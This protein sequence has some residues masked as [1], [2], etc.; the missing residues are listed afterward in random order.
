[1]IAHLLSLAVRGPGAHWPTTV[2]GAASGC[3]SK[4]TLHPWGWKPWRRGPGRLGSPSLATVTTVDDGRRST[5]SIADDPAP[6]RCCSPSW[7]SSSSDGAPPRPPG[8]RPP[9]PVSARV[10]AVAGV[11]DPTGR[12]CPGRAAEGSSR[13]LPRRRGAAGRSTLAAEGPR[14]PGRPARRAGRAAGRVGPGPRPHPCAR[15]GRAAPVGRRA[16]RHPGPR[17]SR[18][19]TSYRSG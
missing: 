8:Q 9:A 18:R 13:H 19:A 16:A 11:A 3:A 5:R 4:G 7:V 2:G 17:P 15:R 10:E 12:T 1:M 14:R 6:P